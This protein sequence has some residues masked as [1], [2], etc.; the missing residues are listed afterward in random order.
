MKSS[1][2]GFTLIELL[3]VISIIGLL[4]SVVLTSLSTARAK[5]QDATVKRN[6]STVRH[7]AALYSSG[8]LN[9][10]PTFSAAACP[11]SGTSMFYTD[12]TMR[13]AIIAAAAAGGGATRCATDGVDFAVSVK[14]NSS[15]DHWCVDSRGAASSTSNTSWT[16]NTCP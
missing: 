1:P 10:G 15:T 6:L 12:V 9:Y 2:R 7:Q 5:A 8:A 11:T 3:V 13:N 4:S 14:L 16:G